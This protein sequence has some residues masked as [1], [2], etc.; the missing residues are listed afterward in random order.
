MAQFGG[1]SLRWL[2]FLLGLSGC[3][4]LASGMQVWVAKR[5]RGAGIGHAV[6]RGLNVG[7]VAG[8]PLAV[9]AM[10]VANRLLPWDLAD[11][12]GAEILVLCAAWVLAAAWG[13]WRE[14]RSRGWRD[15]YAGT[16]ALLLSLPVVNLLTTPASHLWATL[17]RGDWALA[18]VDLTAL[19]LGLAFAWLA[20]RQHQ[21]LAGPVD[22]ASA[23][24]AE[25]S[26]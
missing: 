1:S 9:A 14:Q 25:A 26:A 24:T 16:A 15:L 7:V 3:V 10:A 8:M 21:G 12:R 13:V 11:R 4:M 6:V 5:R 23:A 19:A 18:A 2:Y 22:A 20:R 17:P